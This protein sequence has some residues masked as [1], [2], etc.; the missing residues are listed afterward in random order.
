MDDE[1]VDDVR[2]ELAEVKQALSEERTARRLAEES[3]TPSHKELVEM[4]SALKKR[5]AETRNRRSWV[6]RH[7]RRYPRLVW[8]EAIVKTRT[9]PEIKRHQQYC[10]EEMVCESFTWAKG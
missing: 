1:V 7:S 8:K 2:E 9:S 10:F 3:H 5:V 6:G 4:M